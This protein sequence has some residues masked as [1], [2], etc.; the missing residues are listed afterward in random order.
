ME[1]TQETA[2]LT[3]VWQILMNHPALLHTNIMQAYTSYYKNLKITDHPLKDFE[4][5]YIFP[6]EIWRI[7]SD[8]SNFP[9]RIKLTMVC[10]FFNENLQITDLYNIEP[11]YLKLLTNEILRKYPSVTKLN[12]TNNS[13]VTDINHL[14][15]LQVL[16]VSMGKC[17]LCN[18]GI[19]KLNLKEIDVSYNLHIKTLN[20][21]SQLRI[22]TAKGQCGLTNQGINKLRNVRDL[23]LT[24]NPTINKISHLKKLRVLNA[25]GEV[26]AIDDNS[27]KNLNLHALDVTNNSKVTNINHMSRLNILMANGDCGLSTVGIIMLRLKVIFADNNKKIKRKDLK[28][29]TSIIDFFQ[30]LE[31]TFDDIEFQ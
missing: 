24:D 25:Y 9:S 31:Y 26:C 30:E 19:K 10:K 2:S 22:L 13:N 16:N 12:L 11:K 28:H 6:S 8:F 5:E 7:I 23:D 1:N 29:M 20:H 15:K 17:V 18:K 27:L 3:K 21:F 14:N 4:L